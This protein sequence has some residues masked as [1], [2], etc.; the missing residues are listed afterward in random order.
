[1]QQSILLNLFEIYFNI[2]CLW[3][4]RSDGGFVCCFG[5][6]LSLEQDKCIRKY[7]CKDLESACNWLAILKN[8][9]EITPMSEE[10]GSRQQ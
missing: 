9:W 6:V 8:V 1:M 5:Y 7:V 4:S 3:N 10:K 2:L